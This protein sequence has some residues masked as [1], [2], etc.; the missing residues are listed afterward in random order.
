MRLKITYEHP[1]VPV[2]AFLWTPKARLEPLHVH[3]SL[4]IG[5]CVSGGGWFYFGE[6]RYRAEPGDIFVVNNQELHIAQSDEAEPSTYIFLNFDPNYLLAEDV[7]LLL[8]FAY[9]PDR[10]RNRIPGDDPLAG[11]L[12]PLIRTVWEELRDRREGYGSM[13]KSAL[14]QLSVLL[15]RRESEPVAQAQWRQLVRD[16]AKIRPVLSFLEERFRDPLDLRSVAER[17]ELG[18]SASRLS[19]AF[20]DATGKTFKDYL[21]Q[22]RLNEAKR[23]LMTTEQDVL[24]VCFA[25]GFQSAATFYRA[26]Q[27]EAGMPPSVY[28]ERHRVSAIFENPAP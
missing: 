20:K 27:A 9:S 18:V 7:K 3:T 12:A 23:L 16:F 1:E 8:P 2:N 22:L 19:H 25:S 15:L 11:R 28:R 5:L 14:L 21:Q 4:E 10:F 26:F 6:K 17:L 24:D 13:V